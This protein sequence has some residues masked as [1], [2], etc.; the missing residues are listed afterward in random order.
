M[1]FTVIF[2]KL[3]VKFSKKTSSIFCHI[4]FL[5]QQSNKN[6]FKKIHHHLF[7][8]PSLELSSLSEI[9]NV[10]QEEEEIFQKSLT[11]SLAKV[12]K[13]IDS[14]ISKRQGDR[15][16]H[17]S[18]ERKKILHKRK[19]GFAMSTQNITSLD[20][21]SYEPIHSSIS[22]NSFSYLQCLACN[23]ERLLQLKITKIEWI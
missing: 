16:K 23:A 9:D 11:V 3:S 8:N 6:Y 10:I 7:N 13:L 19:N 22:Q 15:W 12:S 1:K 4:K 17:S 21:S 18:L 5:L 2:R 14:A 20:G